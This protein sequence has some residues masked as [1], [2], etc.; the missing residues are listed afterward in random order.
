MFRYFK[1]LPG[2]I[3]N[4]E[5]ELELVRNKVEHDLNDVIDKI[6]TAESDIEHIAGSKRQIQ[7]EKIK[8]YQ[9]RISQ[10][11]KEIQKEVKL[12]MKL[13]I[14]KTE[15]EV[16]L[17]NLKQD[18]LKE[19]ENLPEDEEL[20][21]LFEEA[22][23]LEQGIE[24]RKND[25]RA[26]YAG[27]KRAISCYET[28]LGCKIIQKEPDIF[29][30]N[31]AHYGRLKSEKPEFYVELQTHDKGETWKLIGMNPVL[32]CREKLAKHLAET[33]DTQG[34]LAYVRKLYKPLMD[35]RLAENNENDNTANKS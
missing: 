14:T 16:K 7:L 21:K 25:I 9:E 22:T 30:F 15:A 10:L 23:V 11:S 4:P 5:Q 32:E 34:L 35:K 18:L 1:D 20:I 28:N 8:S 27:L 19:R 13:S 26:E 3:A 33:K 12:T 17:K 24:K 2:F 29:L 6:N 31:L